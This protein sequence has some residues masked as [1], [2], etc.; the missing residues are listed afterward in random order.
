M[1]PLPEPLTVPIEGGAVTSRIYPSTSG[2]PRAA[3][4]LA[5]GAGASQLHPFMTRC[6]RALA[7]RGLDVATFDF[8]YM[9]RMEQDR[10]ATGTSRRRPPDRA[11]V[12]EACY[13]AVVS[14]VERD[15]SSAGRGLFIGGKSMG[16]RIA[17]QLAATDR[18]LRV[19]G[20]VLL[21]YPLH[22][23]VNPARPRDAHLPTVGR[24]ALFIQGS[25]D[26]FGTPAE[27]G[28]VLARMQPRPT[29]SVVE[30]GD[31][32]FVVPG[33]GRQGHTII[34]TGIYETIAR[35]ILE[36]SR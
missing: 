8:P 20:L 24:P 5:H 16:G 29:L 32:S 23:P 6:A 12:L 19:D 34:E 33:A 21:G 2:E 36:N 10:H 17:T 25:R 1:T 28:P 7:S 9:E 22:P 13:R 11:P 15:V 14:V 3:V 27:L 18:D 31:H 35:W 30:G 4:V 26:V